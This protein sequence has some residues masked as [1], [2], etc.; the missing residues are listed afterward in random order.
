MD[1]ERACFQVKTVS[2]IKKGIWATILFRPCLPLPFR[3]NSCPL[4][5]GFSWR[6]RSVFERG[7]V[8]N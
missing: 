2:H 3:R 7:C 1:V 6:C 8:W 5:N 4:Y